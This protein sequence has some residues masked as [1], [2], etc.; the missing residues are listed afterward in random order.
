MIIGDILSLIKSINN[1]KIVPFVGPKET[2]PVNEKLLQDLPDV[3]KTNILQHVTGFPKQHLVFQTF[4]TAHLLKIPSIMRRAKE[5]VSRDKSSFYD[6]VYYRLLRFIITKNIK[7]LDPLYMI[8]Y[9]DDNFGKTIGEVII[10]DLYSKPR[11]ITVSENFQN[12]LIS[13]IKAIAFRIY[14]F[15]DRRSSIFRKDDG[16]SIQHE[17]EFGEEILVE[18]KRQA[19]LTSNFKIGDFKLGENEE[20]LFLN[21]VGDY[22][23]KNICNIVNMKKQIIYSLTYFNPGFFCKDSPYATKNIY[24]FN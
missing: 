23:Q 19:T 4:V 11:V 17:R 10:G 21:P 9:V 5:M 16:I 18:L 1:N 6:F 3:L 24:D 8:I 14:Y 20:Q 7:H 15:E 22:K 13:N 12:I 2:E